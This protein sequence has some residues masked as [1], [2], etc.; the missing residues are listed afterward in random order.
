[1]DRNNRSDTQKIN[2]M[3]HLLIFIL[4]ILIGV[5]YEQG[6]DKTKTYHKDSI[7]FESAWEEVIKNR[8]Q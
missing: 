2:I 6:Y 4:G 5:C 1:L 7:D 8:K 3:T